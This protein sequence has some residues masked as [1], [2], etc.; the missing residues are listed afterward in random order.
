MRQRCYPIDDFVAV[1]GFPK[2]AFDAVDKIER[3]VRCP[4]RWRRLFER[5]VPGRHHD[6]AVPVPR[7]PIGNVPTDDGPRPRIGA[8]TRRVEY[9]HAPRL[10]RIT[11]ETWEESTLDSVGV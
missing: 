5:L 3:E 6:G 2:S 11:L 9:E 10:H 7:K 1:H 8:S 4:A